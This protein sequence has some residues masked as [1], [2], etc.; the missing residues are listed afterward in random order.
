MRKL[1]DNEKLL[2]ELVY[3]LS[4]QT[5][6][7]LKEVKFLLEKPMPAKRGKNCLECLEKDKRA[8]LNEL[9]TYL[10]EMDQDD[11]KK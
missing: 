2:V 1:T 8:F 6:L 3:M 4:N 9:I 5:D 7:S 10:N 11:V